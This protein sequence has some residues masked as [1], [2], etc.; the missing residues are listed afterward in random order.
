M[1]HQSHVHGTDDIDD[2]DDIVDD[3]IM[4]EMAIWHMAIVLIR[5]THQSH[6]FNS[7]WVALMAY[8]HVH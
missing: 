5:S 1:A 3:K 8:T 4:A 7:I 6:Q 2:I